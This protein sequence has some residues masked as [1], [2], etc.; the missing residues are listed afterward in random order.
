MAKVCVIPI[1]RNAPISETDELV[2]D[3]AFKFWLSSAFRG[4][5][6][7]DAFFTAVR[8]VKGKYSAGPFLVPK[9]KQNLHPIIVMKERFG[10][11]SHRT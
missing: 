3:L 2:A 9:R 8:I 10:S 11:E 6:P 7:K 4:G 5:L 1:Q